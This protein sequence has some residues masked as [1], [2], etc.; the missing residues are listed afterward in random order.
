MI[1]LHVPI[2]G[3][4]SHSR[5]T[6]VHFCVCISVLVDNKYSMFCNAERSRNVSIEGE[7]S[8]CWLPQ[9]RAA[10]FEG[11]IGVVLCAAQHLHLLPQGRAER[12]RLALPNLSL[13]KS[14]SKVALCRQSADLNSPAGHFTC[15]SICSDLHEK[16]SGL[17]CLLYGLRRQDTKRNSV[18]ASYGKHCECLGRRRAVAEA[19][20]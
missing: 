8:P 1:R 11:Q 12:Q 7:C 4:Q 6:A 18:A 17:V 16:V 13:W 5:W 9:A 2:Q 10:A 3:E 14:L 20:R 19:S 15:H